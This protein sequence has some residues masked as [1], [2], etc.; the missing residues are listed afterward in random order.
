MLSVSGYHQRRGYSI[1]GNGTPPE[2]LSSRFVVFDQ[3]TV[4]PAQQ[5]AAD[6]PRRFPLPFNNQG[7]PTAAPLRSVLGAT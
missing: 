1:D 7:R 2:E 6:A 4:V 3:N 5:T